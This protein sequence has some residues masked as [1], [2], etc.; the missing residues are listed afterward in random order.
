MGGGSDGRVAV[1]RRGFGALQTRGRLYGGVRS[2]GRRRARLTLEPADHE[3]RG[4]NQ[5]RAEDLIHVEGQGP[6]LAE[7][8]RRVVVAREVDEEPERRVERDVAPEE[9]PVE[10]GLLVQS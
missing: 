5:E 9:P 4:E 10:V 6:D 1:G 8:A 7:I 3:D 2:Q